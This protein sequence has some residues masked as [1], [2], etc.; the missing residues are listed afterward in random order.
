MGQ[1]GQTPGGGKG[2]RLGVA[3]GALA[4][5][6]PHY[7]PQTYPRHQQAL[8]QGVPWPRGRLSLEEA[9]K[10][11]LPPKE[12]LPAPPCCRHSVGAAGQSRRR[13]CSCPAVR[14][15]TTLH[16]RRGTFLPGYLPQVSPAVEHRPLLR[17][18]CAH[19]S[20]GPPHPGVR[21]Q[22]RHR[23]LG[24]SCVT[25]TWPRAGAKQ[26]TFLAPSGTGSLGG[27]FSAVRRAK[28]HFRQMPCGV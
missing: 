9:N 23:E 21:L 27:C 20:P 10:G 7:R 16:V 26:P 19:G 24:C 2:G 8:L 12:S 4:V 28:T 13:L 5:A 15:K 25:T 17:G 22:L 11:S 6:P 18:A 3:S 1:K 14:G